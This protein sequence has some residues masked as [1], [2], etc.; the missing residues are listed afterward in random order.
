MRPIEANWKLS[1]EP[2]PQRRIPG[3]ED[4]PERG[5]LPGIGGEYPG[6]NDPA[7]L[8]ALTEA[9]GMG[10]NLLELGDSRGAAERVSRARGLCLA[11]LGPSHPLCLRL[12]NNLG[13]CVFRPR[14]AVKS[15]EIFAEVWDVRSRALGERHPDSLRSAMNLGCAM[16]ASGGHS[17]AEELLTLVMDSFTGTLGPL[18]EDTLAAT[19]D[20]GLACILSGD[21]PRGLELV[22]RAKDGFERT[23]GSGSA[24][25][26]VA[27]R[28]LAFALRTAGDRDA[29]YEVQLRADMT[30]DL[31]ILMGE[32]DLWPD[33]T[34]H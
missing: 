34:P 29:A 1:I 9:D 10:L 14:D 31:G 32:P 11:V 7:L 17:E 26:V 25:A 16:S 19:M 18:H 2:G 6:V 8:K 22:A 5:L 27:G 20:L 3:D 33:E 13:C 24:E 12:A 23:L 30:E 28:S 15:R 4:E 21:N